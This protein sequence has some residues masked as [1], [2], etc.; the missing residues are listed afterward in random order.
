MECSLGAIS[1]AGHRRSGIC[2]LDILERE[3]V[4]NPRHAGRSQFGLP[5]AFALA[6]PQTQSVP[7]PMKPATAPA[8]RTKGARRAETIQTIPQNSRR[9]AG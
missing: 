8:S 3:K 9:H 6:I 7:S 4:I 5:A 2:F 1:N